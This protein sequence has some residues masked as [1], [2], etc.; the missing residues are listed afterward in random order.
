MNAP[1]PARAVTQEACGGQPRGSGNNPKWARIVNPVLNQSPVIRRKD[2]ERLVTQKR[3]LWV[4]TDQ[5]R[6]N[7]VHEGNQ[8]E[9]AG[10]AAGY[11]WP[12]GKVV[13]V[14]ELLNI[15]VVR[16]EKAITGAP[17]LVARVPRKT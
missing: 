6:L 2:A 10:A 14:R 5:L 13:T 15:G 16:P 12:S 4:S 8:R 7:L 17:A 11:E 3:A 9:A 1:T